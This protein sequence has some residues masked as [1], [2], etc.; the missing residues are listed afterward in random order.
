MSDLQALVLAAGKGTR[1]KSGM[2]KVLHRL[3][4]RPMIR[5]VVD[6]ALACGAQRVV[7]VVGHGASQVTEAVSGLPVD[8]VTQAEQLG[9]GHAVMSAREAVGD[10]PG[11]LLILSGDVPL[12]GAATVSSLARLQEER[13]A[14]CALLTTTL[15]DPTGYGRIIT[16]PGGQVSR[17]VEQADA[18]LVQQQVRVINA[19]IYCFRSDLL[20]RTLASCGSDN[21]QG[22]YYLTD[23][24]ATIRE[25]GHPVAALEVPDP[26][27]VAGINTR[28]EL[29]RMGSVLNRRKLEKLMLSG[30]T[31]ISPETTRVE[32]DVEVGPDTTIHAHTSL[33]G[34]TRV[35]A[36]CT[37]RSFSRLC[38]A[39]LADGAT[40]A[41]YST[42]P[43]GD[44]A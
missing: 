6:T 9:T 41:E 19:G 23:A 7:M 12:L 31:V 40:V 38:D 1:M 16:D 42:V 14:G 10:G 18:D 34:H 11:R 21:A 35:G 13:G 32:W 37:I 29:A 24:I 20:F 4:G 28:L 26:A 5:F 15:D 2:P 22:E 3:A 25:A 30:V 8:F 33:E 27:E 17:I 39:T 43:G 36:G 44:N